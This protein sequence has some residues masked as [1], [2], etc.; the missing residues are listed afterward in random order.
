MAAP[1]AATG[2]AGSRAHQRGARRA[3]D[4][5]RTWDRNDEPPAARAVVGLLLQDWWAV[6]T[7]MNVTAAGQPNGVEPPAWLMAGGR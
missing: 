2:G 1:P 5:M 4:N 3:S 7:V 6:L